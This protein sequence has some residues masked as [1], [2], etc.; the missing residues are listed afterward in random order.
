MPKL[1]CC[2]RS[3]HPH[4]DFC[5][6][7][8]ES[9]QDGG[10]WTSVQ[11]ICIYSIWYVCMITRHTGV[12]PAT[13]DLPSH[14]NTRA[15]QHIQGRHLPTCVHCNTHLT[16]YAGQVAA[17]TCTSLSADDHTKQNNTDM[18]DAEQGSQWQAD[19]MGRAGLCTP[20]W[21][22]CCTDCRRHVG[23]TSYGLR[24]PSVGG[25]LVKM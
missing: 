6:A 17:D 8:H 12:Y 4:Q 10:R 13:S 21:K 5:I 3:L 25:W 24:P 15:F 1:P 16:L 20:S 22:R 14:F 18:A 11:H 2:H 23:T 19:Q 9:I 7:F